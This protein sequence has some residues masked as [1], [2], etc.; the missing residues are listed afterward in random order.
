MAELLTD[1]EKV[2][3]IK[4]W[5]KANGV[6]VVAGI[7][8][9]LG[10]VLGW[11]AW[12]NHETRVAQQASIAFEQLLATVAAGQTESAERQAQTLVET[13]GGTPY[14][15]FAELAVAKL[16]VESGDLDGAARALESALE[17]APEPGLADLA[18]LRL[19]RVLLDRGDLER[20]ASVIAK[21]EGGA[22]SGDFAALRGDIAAEQ[23]RIAD[24]RT[25]YQAAIDGNAGNARLIEL[26][27]ENLPADDAS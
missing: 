14:A 21:H 20:A 16:R 12:V 23:G 7:A 17:R 5:W 4:K 25:A 3:A 10:A 22:F 13:H 24:A 9:G 27:L 2:E 6:S 11:R 15:M 8:I 18:A 1:E 19:A 26:K